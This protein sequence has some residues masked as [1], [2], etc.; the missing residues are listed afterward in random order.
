ML[1]TKS[2]DAAEL[3]KAITKDTPENQAIIKKFLSDL[4]ATTTEP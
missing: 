3:L 1:A 4:V 2:V